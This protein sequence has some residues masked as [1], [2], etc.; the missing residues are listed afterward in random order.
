MFFLKACFCESRMDDLDIDGPISQLPH[1]GKKTVTKIIHRF[2]CH[3]SI[4][5]LVSKRSENKPEFDLF[6]SKTILRNDDQKSTQFSFYMDHCLILSKEIPE[7]PLETIEQIISVDAL[8]LIFGA[9]ETWNCLFISKLWFKILSSNRKWMDRIPYCCVNCLQVIQKSNVSEGCPYH[10]KEE[11]W[12][13]AFCSLFFSGWA[14]CR[15]PDGPD[16]RS[17]GCRFRRHQ[18]PSFSPYI[19]KSPSNLGKK[20]KKKNLFSR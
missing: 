14:C 4:R 17:S 13:I 5:E 1:V 6:I 18:P 15:K 10:P 19:P 11:C 8:R 20:K 3:N 12:S 16:T 7:K 9:H 2:K